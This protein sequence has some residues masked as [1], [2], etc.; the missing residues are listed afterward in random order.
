MKK[1]DY[2][3]DLPEELIAQDPLPD[4]S[5]SRLMILGK[6]DGHTEHRHFYELPEFLREGDCLVLNDTKVMPARLYGIKE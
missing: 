4:R 6:E 5:S 2:Y 1:S 3:Y